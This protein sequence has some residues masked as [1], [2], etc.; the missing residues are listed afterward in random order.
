MEIESTA[1]NSST[2]DAITVFYASISSQIHTYI[3]IYAIQQLRYP[4]EALQFF[5]DIPT[6][7]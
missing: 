4:R 5:A 3:Y 7:I 1:G 6:A 2:V